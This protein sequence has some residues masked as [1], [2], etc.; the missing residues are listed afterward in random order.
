MAIIQPTS[1][2]VNKEGKTEYRFTFGPWNIHPGADPFGPAVRGEITFAKK[3]AMYRTLGF[4]GVQ[5]HDDDAVPGIMDKSL[6]A[7]GKKA[8][9]VKS[10]LDGESLV[11]EFVAPRLWEDNRTIDGAYTSNNPACRQYAIDRSKCA[12]DVAN[13]LGTDLI[14]LWLAREGTYIREAKDPGRS[15]EYLVNAI[16]V[17]LDYDPNIRIAVE[18]KPNEPMDQAYIPTTGHAVALAFMTKDQ[19]RVGVNIE[20]AHAILAGLDPSDEMGFAL[21]CNKLW[22]VHLNDQNGPKYDQDKTFGSVDIRRAFNQV[23]VLEQNGY[24]RNGEM[25][26]LDVKAMRTQPADIATK[27]LLHSRQ[28]FLTLVDK[29]RTFNWKNAEELKRKR[30]YEQLE[31]EILDHIMGK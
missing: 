12:I 15:V 28:I 27:H 23:H 26:G 21:A 31:V 13:N 22:T 30:D 29:V 20:S 5:F 16:N 8:R 9:E 6:S 4:A 17:M 3:V 14:V 1:Q 19:S 25:V 10:M 18:P 11:A 2:Y 24:G 7:V